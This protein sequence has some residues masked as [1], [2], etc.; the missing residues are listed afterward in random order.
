MTKQD[1]PETK[2]EK[3]RENDA[4]ER[5]REREREG[6]REGVGERKRKGT[7]SRR[8]Q[9]VHMI[10]TETSAVPDD[11]AADCSRATTR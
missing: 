11:S 1:K 9:A 7:P 8:E 5:E 2:P 3:E 6:E 10:S 4:R